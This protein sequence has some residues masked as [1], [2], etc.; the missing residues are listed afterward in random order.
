MSGLTTENTE[1]TESL[2]FWIID[3][4]GFGMSEGTKEARGPFKSMAAAEKWLKADAAETFQLYN[5]PSELG[6]DRD[7]ACP[8]LIVEEKKKVRQVPVVNFKISL[9]E[10]E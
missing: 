9:E 6:A 10:V 4:E 2:K 1:A 5:E 7:W 8:V 3:L